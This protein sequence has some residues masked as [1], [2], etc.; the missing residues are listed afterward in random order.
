M[1]W[2]LLLAFVVVSIVGAG[3]LAFYGASVG[4]EQHSI[5]QVL[6][7]DRFPK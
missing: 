5:E 1:A 6:P 4:P 2:K 3:A 7:D